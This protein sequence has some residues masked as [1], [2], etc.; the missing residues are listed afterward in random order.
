LFG[1]R[2]EIFLTVDGK[3]VTLS[4]FRNRGIA[5]LQLWD[6]QAS[7]VIATFKTKTDY[8]WGNA[9]SRDGKYLASGSHSGMVTIWNV[10]AGSRQSTFKANDREIYELAVGDDGRFIASMGANEFGA[11]DQNLKLKLWRLTAK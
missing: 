11:T 2:V 10:P 8:G 6:V 4:S 5:V 3:W 7:K 9:L 1:Y